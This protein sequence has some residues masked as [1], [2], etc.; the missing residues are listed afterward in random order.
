MIKKFIT[1]S[2]DIR[3]SAFVWNM[4]AALLNSFQTMLFMLVLTR[5]QNV[6][7][8]AYIAI[9]YSL[10]NL[11]MTIGKFGIR[12][13]QA[14]DV[15]N[16]HSFRTYFVSR[17]ITCGCMILIGGSYVLFFWIKGDYSIEKAIVIILIIVLKLTES[18]ED[19]FHGRMQ[20]LGRLD[21]ASKILG[22]RNIILVAGF[23]IGYLCT[24]NLILTLVINV[25]ISVILAFLL[26]A[27][28]LEYCKEDSNS[29][30]S[31]A[32]V[33]DLFKQNFSIFVATF[34]LMYISNAPKY[35]IDNVATDEEQTIFNI[36][37]LVIYVVTLLSNFVFNPIIN[38]FAIMWK[39]DET[40]LLLKNILKLILLVIGIV[41][42]GL[43][44]AEVCGRKILS[45]IY[46]MDLEDYKVELRLM[47]IAGGLIAITNLM[48]MIIILVRKQMVFYP[49]F[50]IASLLLMIPGKTL[51]ING[52]F[53]ALSIYY[54]A[55]LL[56]LVVCM[57][58]FSI[59]WIKKVRK[60]HND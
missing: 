59:Y 2:N 26:N 33:I 12:N 7:G 27:N 40:K 20:Q 16:H 48:Y 14:T 9:A 19:V 58:S 3:K 44:F 8:A 57:V 53:R 29:K 28:I 31:R 54:L 37:F 36:L 51:F 21:V 46:M 49:L 32:D 56:L 23:I 42:F 38:K 24:R 60:N 1:N 30:Y 39:N 25:I 43:V 18:M 47:L 17:I 6:E 45:I 13:Y 50:I 4:V 41:V 35:I 22:I 5:T 55:I 11:F 52:G 15:S 10:A 34:L